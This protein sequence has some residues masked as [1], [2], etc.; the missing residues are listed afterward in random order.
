M[1]R[2]P[3]PL[4]AADGTSLG[5]VNTILTRQGGI[6][7]HTA[8]SLRIVSSVL[9]LDLRRTAGYIVADSRVVYE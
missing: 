6:S 8:N 9:A 1:P 7:F 2:A 5:A 4:S 3:P